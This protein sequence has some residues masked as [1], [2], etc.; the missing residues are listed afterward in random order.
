MSNKKYK[1]LMVEDD[2]DQIM[3]YKMQFEMDGFKFF[4]GKKY[5]EIKEIIEKENPD[6][7]LLDLLL[8]AEAGEDILKKFKTEKITDKIPVFV[9]TNLKDE[10]DD[11]KF[12]EM[13]ARGYWPKTKYLPRQLSEKITKYLSK[14]V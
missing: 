13:G 9:F 3:M 6:I 2:I 8:G 5:V 1:I 12:L 14:K 10:K 7:I 4:N 11:H